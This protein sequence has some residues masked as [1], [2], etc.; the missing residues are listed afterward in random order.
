[1]AW[2]PLT[3]ADCAVTRRSVVI[4]AHAARSDPLPS[5]PR[6]G[7]PG[8]S[9]AAFLSLAV[10][11]GSATSC[12]NVSAS[13]GKAP[14]STTAPQSSPNSPPA[15][16][17]PS[18]VA[19]APK[20]TPTAP[21]PT[22]APPGGTPLEGPPGPAQ[23][24]HYPTLGPFA[25]GHT[26]SFSPGGDGIGSAAVYQVINPYTSSAIAPRPGTH[27]VA[28]NARL[29]AG[30]GA[31]ASPN[32]FSFA[33]VLSNGQLVSPS[34]RDAAVP[35]LDMVDQLP[36]GQCARGYVTFEAP[37]GSTVVGVQYTEVGPSPLNVRW[38]VP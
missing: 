2:S 21:T 28:V 23:S 6:S 30:D 27:F 10:L 35:G 7:S 20:G 15:S 13:S 3:I 19:T 38:R 5:T 37:S 16:P 14:P 18:H 29:C 26:A 24:S 34:Y 11:A 25:L 22:S 12:G 9:L 32:V 33:L 8:H 31:N 1:M 36:P 17:R 4:M